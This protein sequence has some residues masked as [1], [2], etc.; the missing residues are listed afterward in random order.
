MCSSDLGAVRLHMK[1]SAQACGSTKKNLRT[2]AEEAIYDAAP[3]IGSLEISGLEEPRPGGFV[4]LEKL[5]G[6]A[7]RPQAGEPLL[8]V[9]SG[10]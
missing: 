3:D 2:M 7:L 8:T 4:S 10:D 1:A 6:S 5:M 9:E